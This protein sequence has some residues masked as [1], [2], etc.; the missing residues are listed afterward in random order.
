MAA[1]EAAP[2]AFTWKALQQLCRGLRLGGERVAIAVSKQR[3]RHDFVAELLRVISNGIDVEIWVAVVMGCF[4]A[5]GI[6]WVPD[7]VRGRLTSRSVVRLGGQA[8]VQPAPFSPPGSLRRAAR[9]AEIKHERTVKDRVQRQECQPQIDFGCPLPFTNIPSLILAS[10]NQT[11]ATF[12]GKGDAK[13]LDHY[14]IAMNC[15]AEKID[16][17]LCHLMLMITLTICAS[18]ETPEVAQGSRTFSAAAKR[19]DPGQLALVMVT[20]MMWFL[21]PTSFPWAKNSGGMAYDVMEMTKKI[22]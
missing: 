17:P 10:F 13:V 21:Y 6:E 20:R 3:T 22:A 14:Q 19:K 1:W 7:S 18:S 4:L 11:K 9:E 16:D 15:L 12:L 5:A 2:D 8:T